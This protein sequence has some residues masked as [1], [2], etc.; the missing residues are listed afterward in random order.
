MYNNGELEE[1]MTRFEKSIADMPVYVGGSMDR[2]DKVEIESD[3]GR[4]QK[5]YMNNNYYNNGSVNQMFLMC[6]HGYAFGKATAL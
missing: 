6:L 1:V 4:I 3:E 5:R 2:A